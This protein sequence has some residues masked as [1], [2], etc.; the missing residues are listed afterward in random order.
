MY[1]CQIAS[2]FPRAENK[3]SLKPLPR[4]RP[5]L[6]TSKLHHPTPEKPCHLQRPHP[7][8]DPCFVC[9]FAEA[10]EPTSYWRHGL[11]G[12][13]KR[14]GVCSVVLLWRWNRRLSLMSQSIFIVEVELTHRFHWKKLR[15]LFSVLFSCPAFFFE[16]LNFYWKSFGAMLNLGGELYE[17]ITYLKSWWF[18]KLKIC[19][20]YEGHQSL[21]CGF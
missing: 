17:V 16:N 13:P 8:R 11:T 4:L 10:P 1:A 12:F 20:T 3:K 7:C 5:S 19:E 15:F 9:F 14:F 2:I 21:S 18:S 6:I